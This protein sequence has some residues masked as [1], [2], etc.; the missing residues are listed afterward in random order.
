MPVTEAP[1]A[2]R[3]SKTTRTL[4]T[5]GDGSQNSL[6]SHEQSV[7]ATRAAARAAHTVSRTAAA[8][9]PRACRVWGDISFLFIVCL[10]SLHL[11][12]RVRAATLT[13]PRPWWG[14]TS[15]AA[16]WPA[17]GST[18]VGGLRTTRSEERRVGKECRSRWSPYH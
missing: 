18:P 6:C 9:R 16:W 13:T 8:D 12:Y 5:E 14:R 17:R 11:R 1:G 15:G 3:Q 10:L 7:P 2:S 4:E